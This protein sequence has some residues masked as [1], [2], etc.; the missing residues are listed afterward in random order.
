MVMVFQNLIGNAVKYRGAQAPEIR[1]NALQNGPN[2]QI[3]V[4]DNGQGFRTSN[5][6]GSS[7]RSGVCTG[8]RCPAAG[9][10]L[11]RASA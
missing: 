1:I 3:A 10:V 6:N 7:S 9:S 5:Q 11:P 8:W 4:K 2:W